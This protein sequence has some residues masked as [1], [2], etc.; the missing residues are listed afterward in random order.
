[1]ALVNLSLTNLFPA[2][3]MI[4]SYQN[5][6]NATTV[7]LQSTIQNGGVGRGPDED[8]ETYLY[9]LQEFGLTTHTLGRLSRP[10]RLRW[11][12][13]YKFNPKDFLAPDLNILALCSKPEE[14]KNII[15]TLMMSR[16][17]E[18]RDEIA[19]ACSTQES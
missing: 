17:M 5:T 11:G 13:S 19:S 1:M 6:T 15:R 3:M 8:S 4:L 18:E 14:H 7:P 10:S 9:G 2:I 12:T 16:A